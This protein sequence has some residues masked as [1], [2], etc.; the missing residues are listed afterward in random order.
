[1]RGWV[2]GA[3]GSAYDL[4][5]LPYGVFSTAGTDPRVGVRIGDFVM[6]AAAVAAFGGDAGDGPHLAQ[7]WSEPTLEPFLAMG[8]EVW[9]IAREWLVEVLGNDVHRERLEPLLLPIGEVT[10]H[11][12][13]AVAD[14][15][16]FYCSE[17]HATNVGRIFRPDGD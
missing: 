5:N 17:H 10:M 7:P 14:Y 11:Q 3:A 15:V 6:E 8:R 16:D 1:M 12:P 9:D 4:D 2:T 13:F